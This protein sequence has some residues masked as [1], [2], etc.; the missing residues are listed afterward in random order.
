MTNM[1]WLELHSVGKRFGDVAAVDSVD[2]SIRRGEFLTLLGASG[3]G[4]S[5]TLRLIAGLEH[6]DSGRILLD[7]RPIHDMPAHRRETAMVFQSYAL[8]PHMTV[9]Q[10]V[11][12]GLE[13]RKVPRGDIAPRV[14]AA[15]KLVE[16]DAFGARY[17]RQL[18]GGQQQRVALARAIVTEP[19]ALLLD[20]PLSNLDAKLRDRLRV[21]LRALQQ[22]LGVTTI[23]V[24]HD[25]GEAMSLSDRVVF[26][27]GGRIVEI[28]TPQDIYQRPQFRST[29][30]FLG[31]ANLL[32][33]RVVTVGG[34]SAALDTALGRLTVEAS[35]AVTADE[36]ML[37]CFR[38][39]DIRL[40]PAGSASPT[41]GRIAHAAYLGAMTDYVVGL[42]AGL[43]LRVHVPG[44][45]TWSIGDSVTVALPRLTALIRNDI[46]RAAA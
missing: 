15:L 41:A 13:A 22:K 39:E 36:S 17:P 18:S 9:R 21:E 24:T 33:G 30:E 44:A 19:K 7:G 34:G 1:P 40:D 31:I 29:A 8:F 27:A 3:C 14:E 45:P 43:S 25:Q 28:G 16:L 35:T 5:T 10:N 12:F 20:E 26:M 42:A 46:G 2:L 4:K 38:P 11:A 32:E 6:I 37:I 23:Y